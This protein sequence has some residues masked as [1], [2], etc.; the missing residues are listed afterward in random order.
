MATPFNSYSFCDGIIASG[1]LR[2]CE[3]FPMTELF[4]KT[5]MSVK[6][7]ECVHFLRFSAESI[8]WLLKNRSR[9]ARVGQN[10]INV[11]LGEIF[12]SWN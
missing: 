1:K 8:L 6:I 12:V 3:F 7:F 10:D 4:I 11:F 9:R 2:D 5:K